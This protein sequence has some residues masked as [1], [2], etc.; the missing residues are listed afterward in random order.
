MYTASDWLF[1]PQGSQLGDLELQYISLPHAPNP[2]PV[3]NTSITDIYFIVVPIN[4]TSMV[5]T[6]LFNNHKMTSIIK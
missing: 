5:T 6:W 2:E 3:K 4:D 1:L